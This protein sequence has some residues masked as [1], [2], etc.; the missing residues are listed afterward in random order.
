MG[1]GGRMRNPIRLFPFKALTKMKEAKRQKLLPRKGGK[2]ANEN[3][4]RN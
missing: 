4:D 1:R 2:K 3:L